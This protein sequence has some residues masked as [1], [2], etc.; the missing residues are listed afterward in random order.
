MPLAGLALDLRGR[1]EVVSMPDR[2]RLFIA[3]SIE[4]LHVAEELRTLLSSDVDV[5]LWTTAIRLGDAIIDGLETRIRK[6]D[7]AILLFTADDDV[8]SRRRRRRAPR[9]NVIFACGLF[10]CVLGRD[11]C[12]VVC[13]ERVQ[14]IPTDLQNVKMASYKLQTS[15]RQRALQ[16]ATHKVRRWLGLTVGS[17][18]DDDLR[19]A[20]IGACDQIREHIRNPGDG[21]DKL[22]FSVAAAR[23]TKGI[24]GY[25]WTY[26][27]WDKENSIG[28]VHIDQPG[29]MPRVDGT[30]YDTTGAPVAFW[31][32]VASCVRPRE[33]E[34]YFNFKGFHPRPRA[35][36]SP[37]GAPTPASEQYFGFSNYTFN[38]PLDQ[39]TS[40][41]GEVSDLNETRVEVRKKLHVELRRCTTLEEQAMTRLER[42]REEI[43]RLVQERL[44]RSPF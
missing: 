17:A 18:V 30:A 23:F 11:R 43:A 3:S 6:F 32:S 4:G 22:P 9:D 26:R 24:E 39:P 38:T 12:F 10:M 7:Y 27:D 14:R 42:D 34:L 19:V 31:S 20:L 21:F 36:D 5:D 29:S 40:G 41:K 44:R 2:P 28:F 1:A 37:A 16:N 35:S 13:D 15:S 33:G 8:V 25:W